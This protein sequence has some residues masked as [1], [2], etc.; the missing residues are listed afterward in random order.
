MLPA[1]HEPGTS[2]SATPSSAHEIVELVVLTADE[3]FLA[4]LREAVGGATRLWHVASA[5][6]VSDLLLAGEVGILVLDGAALP[7]TH[8]RFVEQLKR[9]FPELVILFAGTREDEARLAT[10]ISDGV[11]YRFIHKP[12]SSARARLFVQAAIRKHEDPRNT[13]VLPA[14]VK[15]RRRPDYRIIGAAAAG[16]VLVAVAALVWNHGRAPIVPATPPPQE[17][18]DATLKRAGEALA[19]NRLID[20]PGDT[21]LVLFLARLARAPNDA[22]A[23]AGL[24]E[25]HERLLARAEN[26][27]LEEQLDEAAKAIE[28]ARRSGVESGRIA[29]LGAQLNKAREQARQAQAR[30][31]TQS[32]Q[33]ADAEKLA[34]A[35]RTASQRMDQGR[36]I[37]PAGDS[38]L[39]FVQQA[40]D[41]APTD[42]GT[43]QAR[44]ALGARL[45]LDARTALQAKDFERSTRLLQAASGIASQGDI[46][47]ARNALAT[48]RGETQGDSREQLLKLANERLQQDRLV[49]PPS[50]SARSR[51]AIESGSK[52]SA[53]AAPASATAATAAP[54]APPIVGAAT[55][56]RLT[57][58]EPDYPVEAARRRLEGWVEIE[59]TVAAD[60]SVRDTLVRNA[61][62]AGVFDQAA[63]SAVQRWRF[64]PVLRDGRPVEQR[65]RIR[66]RFS[67]KN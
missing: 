1:G 50:D 54:T 33:R 14:L 19:A 38:A 30:Q 46:D 48:A 27:L 63:A 60:G 31:R 67:L 39:S 35:L 15:P 40:I 53:A 23:R 26:A 12:M 20:P 28:D 65:S 8:A 2:G 58:V 10:L 3:M 55:L 21:A 42:L 36:L 17:A 18:G 22:A 64:E 32:E 43:Q 61:Q 13:M 47:A 62:P 37:E 44:R 41:L 24:A 45:L 56:K 25:V 6:K 5:D 51:N 9:Q 7:G 16:V 66:I 34:K 4:V 57:T 52:A 11:V 29:F 49:D 59:F